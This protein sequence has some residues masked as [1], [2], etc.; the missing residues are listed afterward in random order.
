LSDGQNLFQRF[1]HI[2]SRH[3][4]PKFLRRCARTIRMKEKG[5]RTSSVACFSLPAG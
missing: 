2:W 3:G 1:N 5:S 4:R